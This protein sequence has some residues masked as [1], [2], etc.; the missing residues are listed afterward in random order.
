MGDGEGSAFDIIC[1]TPPWVRFLWDQDPFV[2]NSLIYNLILY[3]SDCRSMGLAHHHI[4]IPSP[5]HNDPIR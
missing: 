4:Y 1:K 5:D 3:T 2:S